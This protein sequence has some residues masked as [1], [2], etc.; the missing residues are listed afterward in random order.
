MY[1]FIIQHP[2][3]QIMAFPYKDFETLESQVNAAFEMY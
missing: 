3:F 2:A 1:C